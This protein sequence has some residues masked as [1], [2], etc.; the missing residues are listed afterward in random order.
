MA[1]RDSKQC[2]VND[3][4]RL[5]D[6]YEKQRRKDSHAKGDAGYGGT[7]LGLCSVYEGCLEGS[8]P[9][10]TKNCLFHKDKQAFPQWLVWFPGLGVMEQV[11][12]ATASGGRDVQVYVQLCHL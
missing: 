12:A 7:F 2:R 10:I 8:I 1:I 6:D 11:K 4:H 5:G 9:W 3:V